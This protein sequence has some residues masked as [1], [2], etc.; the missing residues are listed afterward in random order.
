MCIYTHTYVRR[1]GE[2]SSGVIHRSSV[3]RVALEQAGTRSVDTVEAGGHKMS[4]EQA[5]RHGHIEQ[6]VSKQ[7]I[8]H[9]TV[10]YTSDQQ[11][12]KH[13]PDAGIA[14]HVLAEKSRVDGG[15]S[16]EET[17]RSDDGRRQQD[18]GEGDAAIK[19]MQVC[20]IRMRVHVF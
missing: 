6:L 15:K 12:S 19:L 17:S 11:S 3:S 8:E 5:I 13:S 4:I 9:T 10:R 18:D 14:A 2:K 16:A 1:P 20:E 7:G